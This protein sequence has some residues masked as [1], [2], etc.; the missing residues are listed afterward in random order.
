MLN[1]I[2]NIA[3]IVMAVAIAIAIL[4]YAFSLGY[5]AFKR[6]TGF[7][8]QLFDTSMKSILGI[9]NLVQWIVSLGLLYVFYQY[10]TFYSIYATLLGVV[11]VY[12]TV[13]PGYFLL[14]GKLEA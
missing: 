1:T 13:V 5:L 8:A 10:N 2:V 14:K 4:A 12:G 6:E 7:L 9:N 11:V 3:D